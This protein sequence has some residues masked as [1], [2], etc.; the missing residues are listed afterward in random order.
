MKLVVDNDSNVEELPIGNLMDV[1][2]MAR[3]FVDQ[4]DNGEHGEVV[5]AMIIVQNEDGLNACLW[6]E[7]ASGFEKI[8]MLSTVQMMIF[9]DDDD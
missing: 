1:S 5:R 3:R 7:N 4:L 8:G 2:G 9:A 6:G